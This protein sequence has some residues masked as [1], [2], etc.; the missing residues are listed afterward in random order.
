MFLRRAAERN[1][2][3]AA[4]ALGETY[5]PA[6]LKDLGVIK[7]SDDMTLAREWYRRAADM[8][9]AAAGSRLSQLSKADQ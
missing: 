3:Q 9:S 7:F 4:R 6:V 5:D 1:D 2:P 8:G